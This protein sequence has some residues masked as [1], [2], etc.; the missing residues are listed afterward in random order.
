VESATAV[1]VV[2]RVER[3]GDRR[4]VTVD[5]VGSNVIFTVSSAVVPATLGAGEDVLDI[6]VRVSA[7]RC[8]PHALAESKK[9]F[10]L[11]VWVA[12]DGGA[13]AFVELTLAGRVR[14]ALD[15]ALHDGCA[16]SG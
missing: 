11:P 16:V 15:R 1:D 14:D 3:R 4:A 7:E 10:Q 2:L 9:T 13:P 6:V 12:L 5:S 8:E